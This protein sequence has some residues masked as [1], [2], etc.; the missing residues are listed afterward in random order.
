MLFTRMA[1]LVGISASSIDRQ[2]A[3]SLRPS[4]LYTTSAYGKRI[5]SPSI[6]ASLVAFRTR[7]YEFL[8]IKPKIRMTPSKVMRSF[9]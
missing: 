3:M 4:L 2:R 5:A 7:L 1:A 8:T 6:R 9:R